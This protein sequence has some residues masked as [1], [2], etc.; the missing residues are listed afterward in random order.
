MPSNHPFLFFL[1]LLAL[2]LAWAAGAR[3]F[4]IQCGFICSFRSE[5]VKAVHTGTG[6][7]CTYNLS[8]ALAS[9]LATTST[10]MHAAIF[11]LV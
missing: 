11:W 9:L 1:G 7:T 6:E 5:C 4:T 8:R 2:R 10:L 3:A